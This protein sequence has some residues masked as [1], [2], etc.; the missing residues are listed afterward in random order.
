M[1]KKPH[2]VVIGSSNTD[3][4]I[5]SK[6]LP[7]P[8]ETVLGDEFFIASGGKGANQAVA[9]ARAGVDVTFI[10]KIGDDAFGKNNIE[11]YKKD[12]IN[13]NHIIIDKNNYSGIALIM[14]DE[15]GEN[16][17]A[18]AS[19]SNYNFT[20]KEIEEKKN[21]IKDADIVLLQ[22]EIPDTTNIR[23]ISI[24]NDLNIPCILNPAPGPKKPLQN[25]VLKKIK[26]LTPNKNELELVS[27][28]KIGSENDLKIIGQELISKGVENVIITLGTKGALYINSNDSIIIPA[29]KVKAIDTVGAGDC[30][31]GYLGAMLA[32]GKS[33]LDSIKIASAAA[34]ISVTRRGAQPSIPRIDEVL[35]FMEKNP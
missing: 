32:S 23:A 16:L 15:Y 7:S 21:V 8:G 28:K 4:T 12:N 22:N 5:K 20:P 1:N 33:I 27:G 18:V 25:D 29:Y 9:A 2:V 31:N 19:N 6:S 34:A 24:S 30:F 17:I 13:T 26:F 10:A 3:L 11:L 35:E 14:I